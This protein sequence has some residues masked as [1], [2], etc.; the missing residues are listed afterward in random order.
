MPLPEILDIG[1]IIDD[2]KLRA[3]NIPTEEIDIAEIKYN[4]DIPYLEQ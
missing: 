2:P 3:I 4:M 1:F